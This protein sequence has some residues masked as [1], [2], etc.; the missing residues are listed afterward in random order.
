MNLNTDNFQ[1]EEFVPLNEVTNTHEVYMG[2]NFVAAVDPH[3]LPLLLKL[4]QMIRILREVAY[5]DRGIN[6][7]P[8]IDEILQTANAVEQHYRRR[9]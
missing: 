1:A 2:E 5:G 6:W 7:R 3:W 8:Q 4:P 9:K